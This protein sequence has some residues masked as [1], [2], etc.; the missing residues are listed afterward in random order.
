[1]CNSVLN[2]LILICI[3]FQKFIKSL[4]LLKYW[5]IIVL[6]SCYYNYY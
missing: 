2:K 4:H 3:L 5:L 1:M 6:I